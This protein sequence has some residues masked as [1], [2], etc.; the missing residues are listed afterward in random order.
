MISIQETIEKYQ[1]AVVQIATKSGTGTGFYLHE[2][3]LIITNNHV[4]DGAKEVQ[5]T[6]PDK[7]EFTGKIVGADP[8]TDL[9][10]VK[11]DAKGLP[12]VPWG[13]SAK[14]QVGV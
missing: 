9:A 13:D 4:V 6:L 7:R 11:I 5:V 2:Y 3:D 8:K 1:N 10:V 12:F 14:L